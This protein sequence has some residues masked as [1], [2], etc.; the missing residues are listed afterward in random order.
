MFWKRKNA[1][2]DSSTI[3]REDSSVDSDHENSTVGTE[4]AAKHG[5]RSD[6][7]VQKPPGYYFNDGLRKIDYVL[8]WEDTNSEESNSS[9]V[10]RVHRRYRTRFVENLQKL[11]VETEEEIYHGQMLRTHYLKLHITWDLMCHYAE[12][13]SL[14]APLQKSAANRRT[15]WSASLLSTLHIPNI[16]QQDVPNHPTD[17]YTCQFRKSKLERFLGSGDR[18]TYFT[19]TQRQQVACEILSTQ[20]YGSRKKAQVGIDRLI[21]EGVYSAAYVIHEGP[22]Q[23]T[24]ED[25]KH[26][27]KMNARQILYWYW[28]RWGCW[29]RYQP[30]DHIR[31]Y[32]GEKIGFYFAWLG[33]Y[34]AWLLPAAVVGILVFLYGLV[35]M[36]D[37]IPAQEACSRDTRMCPLCEESLGCQYWNLR[38]MCFYLK[39]SYLFDHPGTVFY[40]IFIVIWGVTFLE[41][42][43]RK[44][45]KLAHRW[46][47]LD[48]EIEEE[49]PR[50]QYTAL[51]SDFAK[52]PI[53][54]ALEPHFPE[55]LRMARVVAGLI[56]ILLMMVL[57]M[58]F[59]VAV[60]IYRLLIMV[61]L[62]K[63]ELLRPNAGIYANMS[64]AMVN[65]VLIMCLGKVYE[66]LAY[67]MTQWEMHRTQS[68]FENQLTFK[69]F[70]F[71]FVNF[72]ASIFY[73]AFF[74]G[75]FIGYPGHYVYFFGLRNEDCNN[76]GCLIELAQQL[77]VIMVGKQ[78]INNCQEIIIPKLRTWWHKYTKGLNKQCIGSTNSLQIECMF[79]EDY[80]LI[81]YEGLFEEY[82]EMVLQFGFVTI[83]V[84]AFPLAPFFA[85]LNNWIEIRLD[86]NKLVRETRRPLSER[87]QNIG[88]WFRILEVLVRIAVISNAFI[89]AFTSQFLPKLLYQYEIN[90]DLRGFTNFTLAWSPPNSTRL[91]CRYPAFRDNNGE[92]TM[93][94][95]RLLALRL[96]FVILFEHVAFLLA[97]LFDF[98]IPDVPSSLAERIQRERFLAKQ[99]LLDVHLDRYS[100]ADPCE[101]DMPEDG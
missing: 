60:I 94:Y 3:Q 61:P 13:L 32:Y 76:G 35:T 16:M 75:R 1:L 39:A 41:Y 50:P 92:Y 43:K 79:M 73:V 96:V 5:R 34:T 59:I 62:F 12:M 74:K 45:A 78:I 6:V 54:G 83:F 27:E 99:A 91:D 100:S 98:L 23:V 2:K 30:L 81:P 17:Y 63:N 46:D 22:Y 68:I 57:V 25:L 7:H 93:F 19:S 28:A 44:N 10:T 48:Y 52:N 69:V 18:A 64:A 31:Q 87:A 24:K 70:L 29:Y 40:A 101:D 49:R 4:S 89:I 67:K 8:V 85:L 55:R 72:Y 95:W 51:C 56:C 11:G 9:K 53:T 58:V 82:L 37:S 86:A 66:K 88:V 36:N 15:N 84:A 97:D 26:P 38:D 42:W 47:V 90:Q 21:E 20:A 80:K 65:L 33:L 71:Q 77:L 14:R